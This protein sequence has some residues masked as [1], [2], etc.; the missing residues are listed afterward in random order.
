MWIHVREKQSHRII[1]TP[2]GL[3]W[4]LVDV[5]V[6]TTVVPCGT[7]KLGGKSTWGDTFDGRTSPL[8]LGVVVSDGR[9]EGVVVV[10][11]G[12]PEGVVVVPV[13]GIWEVYGANCVPFGKTKTTANWST[14]VG[15]FGLSVGR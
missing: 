7:W 14:L 11:D 13:D 3:F 9:P 15:W 6:I 12:T 2:V 8:V 4:S 1:H 10:S 5:M